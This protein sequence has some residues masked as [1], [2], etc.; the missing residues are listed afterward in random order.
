MV[1][2]DEQIDL[3][4][5]PLNSAFV[6]TRKQSSA[7]LSYIEGHHAIREANRIFGFGGWERHTVYCKEVC[8]YQNANGNQVVGY[9]AKVAV[10]VQG[11][12][13]EGTGHGQGISKQLFDAIEGAAKE[14]ETDAMKRALM[15]FGDQFGLALYDK[16]QTHVVDEAAATELAKRDARAKLKYE[17]MLAELE[18]IYE[19]DRMAWSTKPENEVILDRMQKHYRK[20]YNDI[21][22]KVKGN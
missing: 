15:T 19:S 9:E 18:G 22:N 2:T 11:V 17:E 7:T 5:K 20:Y 6:S 16:A 8:R 12:T 14:A 1:F 10:T 13:R 21:M 3:L 4:N